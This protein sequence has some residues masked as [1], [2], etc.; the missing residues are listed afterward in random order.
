MLAVGACVNF[1]VVN[2]AVL[3]VVAPIVT[4]F[5]LL[6]AV[7][8]IITEPPSPVG[9]IT[10]LLFAGLNVVLPVVASAV[11][12]IAFGIIDPIVTLLDRPPVMFD[13]NNP[14]IVKFGIALHEIV[15]VL[16]ATLE[17]KVINP[18]VF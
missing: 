16:E 1:N 15:N 3:G 18:S 4:L 2:F 14:E 9:R 17:L 6:T 11:T 7:G 8:F 13:V 12:V 10:T 5:K